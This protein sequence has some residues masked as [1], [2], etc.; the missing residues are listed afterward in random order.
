MKYQETLSFNHPVIWVLLVPLAVFMAYGTVQQLVLGQAFGSNPAPDFLL[1]IFMLIPLLL[2]L[3]FAGARLRYRIDDSGIQYRF[4]PFH[5]KA[6][7]L[8]WNEID[9]IYVRKYKAILEFGGWGLRTNF[10][11]KQA[12]NVMGDKGMGLEVLLKD[13]KKILFSTRKPKQLR[14]F[15]DELS[16]K[17][18]PI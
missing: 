4:F 6:H 7:K 1:V 16:S 3:L 13:K 9:E 2:L 14:A 17:G 5:R 11:N 8:G 15:L 12:Y 18:I 10:G